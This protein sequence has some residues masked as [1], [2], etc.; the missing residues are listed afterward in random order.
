MTVEIIKNELGNPR[1][2]KKKYRTEIF[3]NISKC[4]LYDLTNEKYEKQNKAEIMK[5]NLCLAKQKLYGF[6]MYK[7]L[8]KANASHACRNKNK[9]RVLEIINVH[10]I[11]LIWGTQAPIRMLWSLAQQNGT[12][13][14]MFQTCKF[15]DRVPRSSL[16]PTSAHKWKDIKIINQIGG[17]RR[18][19]FSKKLKG[20]VCVLWPLT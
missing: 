11:N 6:I 3:Y 8:S 19:H 9:Q 5:C 13:H 10:I 20:S 14:S 17:K 15:H 12:S 18:S 4:Q 1:K 2:V 16:Y 7:K